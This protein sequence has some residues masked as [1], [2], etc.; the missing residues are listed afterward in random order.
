MTFFKHSM[1]ALLLIGSISGLSQTGY[2]GKK[3]KN[4]SF[5]PEAW[6]TKADQSALLQKTDLNTVATGKNAV[7]TIDASRTYQTIDGF[8]YTLTGG[9]AVLI[10]QLPPG[11]KRALLEELFG[12]SAGAIGI[13]Y[14]RLSIGSSDLDSATFSYNDLPAGETDIDQ[15][16][17]SL[18]PD[19][20]NLIPV[21]KD[22]LAINPAIK[23]IAAP[24]SAPAWMKDNNSTKGGSLKP[25][26]YGSYATYFVKYIREMQ[27][28]GIRV[29]AITPQNEPYH[30]GNNPSLYMTAAMQRDFIKN[31]LGPAFSKNNIAT[32]IVVYDHNLDKPLYADTIYQDPGAARYVVG[33]AFHL[34]AG[35][36]SAM[37][38]LHERYP[39][40]QLY[41]TEQWTGSREP[42]N[43]TLLWHVKNVIIG[44]LRNWS[45]IALEWNLANDPSFKPHTPGGCT[46]CKGA[47]TI[48]GSSFTRNVSYYI[49]AHASKF[50]P[51]GSKRIESTQVN[52]LPNA[53]FITP[54]GKTILLVLNENA[55]P[56][57]VKLQEGR[58]GAA[59]NLPAGCVATL[60]W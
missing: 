18:E 50:I 30:P 14:L 54:A 51:P 57:A 53:A 32:K 28:E 8:G 29:T 43:T 21:L 31:D 5:R 60:V 1:T 40:K 46:E 45:K 3:N 56:A 2:S 59:I 27:A 23:I 10:N 39:D 42:F 11:K 7:I 17:F 25:E 37:G 6:I 20:A 16:K 33:A 36:V 15:S 26:Y 55:V 52:G 4:I 38:Q 44:T 35:D 47:I 12:K 13:S 48:D 34:Y 41:F 9:S 58:S 24:W 19:K 49:I 22:I